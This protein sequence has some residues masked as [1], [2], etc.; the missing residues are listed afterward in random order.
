MGLLPKRRLKRLADRLAHHGVN[1]VALPMTNAW[2]LGRKNRKTPLTRPIAPISQLQ[3]AGVTVAI[4]GDNVQ[5]PW[6]PIGDF[7]PVSLM[8]F[9]MVLAQLAPWNRL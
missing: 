3:Q 2:L 9:S 8:S 6:F 4:G 5:D 7:D 1:A